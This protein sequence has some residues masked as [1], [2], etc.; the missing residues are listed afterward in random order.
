MSRT[1]RIDRESLENQNKT[2]NARPPEETIRGSPSF[3]KSPT[4]TPL[5]PRPRSH[6]GASGKEIGR[7]IAGSLV[8]LIVSILVVTRVGRS[9][10]LAR[11]PVHDPSHSL[12]RRAM[13]HAG[14]SRIGLNQ[15]RGIGVLLEESDLRILRRGGR[16]RIV[17]RDQ[18]QQ[19]RRPHQ[20]LTDA[21]QRCGANSRSDI[22]DRRQQAVLIG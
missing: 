3:P 9:E 21:S 22:A 8:A 7:L 6:P 14:V 19:W 15:R 17:I 10:T 1:P 4:Q 11:E 20:M 12:R 18:E 16:K 13:K 2:H 5:I